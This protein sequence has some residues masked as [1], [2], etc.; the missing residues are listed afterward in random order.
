MRMGR[1]LAFVLLGVAV[2]LTAG[3]ACAGSAWDDIRGAL[4]GDR[5]I[6]DGKDVLAFSAPYRALEQRAVPISVDAEFADGRGVKTVTFVVD[7]NPMPVAAVF[8]LA[9]Q[10]ERL[11][12]GANLR[13]DQASPVRVV[14]E[15]SDGRLYMT[16]TFVKAS[17][18][19][20][21]AAPPLSD[22]NAILGEMKL[23][24]LTGS[25]A[26]AGMTRFQRRAQLDITHPQNTGMQMNQITMLYIPLRFISAV[27]VRQ[28]DH[29]LFD[30]DGSMS[31][32]ENP[33]IWFD[34]RVNGAGHIAVVARDTNNSVWEQE[35]PLGSGS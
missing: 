9:E 1:K 13:L 20:V 19:G 34:Y 35:F 28:G 5:A 18:L 11:R 7:E 32:S 3:P 12:L 4:F 10:R 27:E 31:L 23:T 26:A 33:R 15:A 24:D 8:R 2:G 6:E 30:L 14:V 21:C 22:Q 16:E 25:D 29:K 17:G